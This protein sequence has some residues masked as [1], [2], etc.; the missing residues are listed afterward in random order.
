MK[1]MVLK[2]QI[3]LGSVNA[4]TWHFDLAIRDLVEAK[5]QFVDLMK[6]IITSRIDC[7]NFKEAINSRSSDDIKTVT[8]W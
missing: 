4:S 2:N 1:Q 5:R 7:S 8:I 3:I 6:N